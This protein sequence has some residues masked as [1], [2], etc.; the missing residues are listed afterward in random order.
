MTGRESQNDRVPA[1]T[2]CA[3]VGQRNQWTT[4]ECE[5]QSTRI[6]SRALAELQ[7]KAG[8]CQARRQNVL[9]K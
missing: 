6:M 8:K 1:P 9:G 3:L 7:G 4:L 5:T 2:R